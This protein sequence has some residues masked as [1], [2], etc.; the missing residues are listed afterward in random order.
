M[1]DPATQPSNN[2]HRRPQQGK[3]GSCFVARHLCR[4]ADVV[5]VSAAPGVLVLLPTVQLMSK[6][7][8]TASDWDFCH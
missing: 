6:F 7:L 1:L 2:V 8:S 4:L 3:A 5:S